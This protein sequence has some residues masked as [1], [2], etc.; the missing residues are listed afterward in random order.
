MNEKQLAEHGMNQ[1]L[2]HVDFMVGTKDVNID[3]IG[4]DGKVVPLFRDG[5]WVI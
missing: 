1:S 5:E 4:Y 2:Q 3:G